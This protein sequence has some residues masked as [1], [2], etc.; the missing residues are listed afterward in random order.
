VALVRFTDAL[1]RAGAEYRGQKTH[2]K[3]VLDYVVKAGRGEVTQEQLMRLCDTLLGMEEL[4]GVRTLSQVG[5]ARFPDNP[6]FPYWEAASWHLGQQDFPP[7]WRIRPLLERAERLAQAR[8]GDQ[9]CQRLLDDIRD[10]MR[11]LSA[12]D[13]FG[14]FMQDFFDPDAGEDEDEFD[15][16]DW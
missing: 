7:L 15:D 5:Q 13:P 16:D 4:R 6:F 14:S 10:K 12:L 2:T 8:L 1:E 9:D 11:L 3:K